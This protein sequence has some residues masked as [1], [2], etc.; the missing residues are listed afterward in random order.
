MK[1]ADGSVFRGSWVHD[2]KCGMGVE[3]DAIGGKYVG[4]WRNG[5]RHGSGQYSWPENAGFEIREYHNGKLVRFLTV[6]KLVSANLQKTAE[7]LDKFFNSF[8]VWAHLKFQIHI[9]VPAG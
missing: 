4:M 7:E 5:V 1:Y 3:T 6:P 9:D 8:V 2:V